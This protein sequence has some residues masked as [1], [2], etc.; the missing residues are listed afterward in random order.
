MLQLQIEFHVGRKLQHARFYRDIL[1]SIAKIDEMG[2]KPVIFTPNGI[3]EKTTDFDNTCHNY[4]DVMF[5]Q[6]EY[7]STHYGFNSKTV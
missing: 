5:V 7:K 2:F 1:K 4:F 6:K 3:M